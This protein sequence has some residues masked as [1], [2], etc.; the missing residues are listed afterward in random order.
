M[1]LKVIFKVTFSLIKVYVYLQKRPQHS[2][3]SH[4]TTYML[5][6]FFP[7][8]ITWCHDIKKVGTYAVQIS[9]LILLAKSLLSTFHELKLTHYL[10][11]DFSTFI[12]DHMRLVHLET[13][14]KVGLYFMRIKSLLLAILG[15]Q[16]LSMSVMKDKSS[17]KT[18]FLLSR[19]TKGLL[20][21][22]PCL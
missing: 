1:I 8:H 2:C 22:S 11:V 12:Y 19:K 6:S 20:Q 4:I 16:S 7:S 3:T 18:S 15:V 17:F 21:R 5:Q 9:D 13:R 14:G 10:E